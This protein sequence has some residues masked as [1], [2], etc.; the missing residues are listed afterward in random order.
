[1][2][3]GNVVNPIRRVVPQTRVV[4]GQLDYVDEQAKRVVV[5]RKNEKEINLP[6]AASGVRLTWWSMLRSSCRPLR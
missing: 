1:M 5:R 2:Q 3:P 4:N 6:Y